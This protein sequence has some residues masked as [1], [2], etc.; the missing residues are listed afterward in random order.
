MLPYEGSDLHAFNYTTNHPW[1]YIELMI[2]VGERMYVRIVDS[3]FLV[4]PCNNVNNYIID[5][6][7]VEALTSSS[8]SIT[9]KV[10]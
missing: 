9:F 10:S 1:G 7:F 3:K 5:R 8:N 2:S 6:P 4:V